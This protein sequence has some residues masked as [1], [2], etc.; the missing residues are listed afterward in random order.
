MRYEGVTTKCANDAKRCG[1][2]CALKESSTTAT[3]ELPSAEEK[4]GEVKRKNFLYHETH[5]GHEKNIAA[6]Q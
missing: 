6:I 5:E 2:L 4:E 1:L 3:L